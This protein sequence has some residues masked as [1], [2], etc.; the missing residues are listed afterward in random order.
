[1]SSFEIVLPGA[2]GILTWFA[3]GLLASAASLRAAPFHFSTGNPTG[4]MAMATGTVKGADEIEAADDFVLTQTTQLTSAS[5]YGLLP[6]AGDLVN[7]S[8]V[9]VEI[10]RIF[11]LDS[12]TGRVPSVP[13]RVNSPADGAFGSGAGTF[14]A[15]LL[16]S[17]FTSANSV[18]NGI[19]PAPNQTTGGEGPVTGAEVRIDFTFTTPLALDAGQYFFVPLVDLGSASGGHFLWLNGTRPITG[20]DT[21]PFLPDLQAW[22]R[23][24]SLAPDWLRV[25]GDI[26]GGGKSYNG[27]F[28]LNGIT[29][30]ATVPDQG[31]S[32]LALLVI[33]L[34]SVT[35][36]RRRF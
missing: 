33:G 2:T 29:G 25:G 26:V 14:A 8:S 11:P 36:V 22:I 9:A 30:S 19:N 32:S 31:G 7:L 15:T 10:Y 12:D 1:M 4:E 20:A 23:D 6:S 27:A 5:F 3:C 16:A 24:E 34:G 35:L 28:E 13:T 17:A 21:T 18:V